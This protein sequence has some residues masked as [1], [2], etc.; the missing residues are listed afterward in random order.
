[1]PNVTFR[2]DERVTLAEGRTGVAMEP[3]RAGAVSFSKPFWPGLADGTITLTFRRWKRPQ[4]V[5]GNDYRTRGRHHRPSSRSTIVDPD[6]DHRH[7]R[8]TLGASIGGGAGR[9][10]PGY[11]RP[12]R[13]PHR[14]PSRRRTRSARRAGRAR[15]PRWR[16]DRRDRAPARPARPRPRPRAV[17]GSGARP[18]RAA[19]RPPRRRPGRRCSIGRRSRSSWTSGS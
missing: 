2:A 18:D 10:P 11:G 16:R 7:R 19:S 17:D 12:P 8:A 5:A 15:P 9:R 13:V 4:A 14:V 3:S 1:M 6:H